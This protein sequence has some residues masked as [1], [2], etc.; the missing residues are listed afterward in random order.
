MA[1]TGAIVVYSD[2]IY[3]GGCGRYNRAM[4]RLLRDL[5]E[6]PWFVHTTRDYPRDHD[7]PEHRTVY[8]PTTMPGLSAED[9]GKV[10]V[11]RVLRLFQ[12]LAPRAVIFSNGSCYSN[13]AAK[14]TAFMLG[15]PVLTIE[16]NAFEGLI[17]WHRATANEAMAHY[18]LAKAAVCVSEYNRDTITRILE[19]PQETAVTIHNFVPDDIID[20]PPSSRVGGVRQSLGV[21]TGDILV[22]SSGSLTDAKGVG[23]ILDLVEQHQAW[24]R[25]RRVK[26][27]WAG[28]P[29][30]PG[31]LREVQQRI[32]AAGATDVFSIV[33]WIDSI[34]DFLDAADIFLL[35]SYNEAFC[36]AIA[37]AMARSRPVITTDRGGIPEVTGDLARLV[38]K[39]WVETL[40]AQLTWM[41]DN[42]GERER[43]GAAGRQRVRERFTQARW[44][45]D[46]GSLLRRHALLPGGVA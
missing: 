16:H 22:V 27:R 39:P 24:V 2:G 10:A 46:W 36:L 12:D 21:A 38:Q 1:G 7:F 28:K 5:G 30:D 14:R 8:L 31:Y 3:H 20:A 40:R 26:F 43:L 45:A 34:T 18:Q 4:L 9:G 33:G 6:D 17:Q 44:V 29:L 13:L 11:L 19:C 15:L 41:L 32:E 23:M 25:S 37:E 42:P 35:P